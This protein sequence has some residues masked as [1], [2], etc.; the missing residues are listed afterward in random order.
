MIYG[1]FLTSMILEPLG[2]PNP[3]T[4]GRNGPASLEPEEANVGALLSLTW[5]V[6]GLG[7]YFGNK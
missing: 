6:G 2:L 5:R 1:I 7:K 4:S 3:E